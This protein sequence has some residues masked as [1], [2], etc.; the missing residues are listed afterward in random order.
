MR[1]LFEPRP[2]VQGQATVRFELW[3][4]PQEPYLDQHR[5]GGEPLLATV[6]GIEALASA[7]RWVDP[8][9]G[10]Q[11]T[12]I[13]LGEPCVL[14]GGKPRRVE[15]DVIR[16]PGVEHLQCCLWSRG[17][18]GTRVEHFAACI[19]PASNVESE[20]PGLPAALDAMSA[21]AVA[22]P[23]TARQVYAHFFHGPAFQVIRTAAWQGQ[24]LHAEMATDLPSW[25]VHAPCTTWLRPRLVEFA[26]QAA[27][28]LELARSG[29]MRIP[30]AIGAIRPS[31]S[32]AKL[33]GAP[34][35]AQAV[36]GPDGALDIDV[37]VVG[38]ARAL[39]VRDYRTV[40]LPF[41]A[42][43]ASLARLRA[44]LRTIQQE[45]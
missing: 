15:I 33:V 40:P 36:V 44:A 37:H 12:D 21:D 29:E 30:Q 27:G 2:V 16:D 3:L 6:L 25:R 28:L 26:L 8:R 43:A 22:Q 23:V 38:G 32:D 24:R 13:R 35:C 31:I 7:A 9:V 14:P 10:A 45:A 11:A 18:A 39:V 1:P 34:F 19:Q 17:P 20:Q 42:D 5:P 41:A 4:E